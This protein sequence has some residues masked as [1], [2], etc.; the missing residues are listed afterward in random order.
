MVT[1]DFDSSILIDLSDLVFTGIV[2]FS[3]LFTVFPP[4]FSPLKLVI[5]SLFH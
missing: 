3:C 4:V 5:L 2:K 1:V